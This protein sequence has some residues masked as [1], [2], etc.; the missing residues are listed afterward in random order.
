MSWSYLLV[1]NEALDAEKVRELIDKQPEITYWYRCLPNSMFLT[2]S[3]SASQISNLIK[4]EFS[5]RGGQRFFI[6]E[7]HADRQGWLPR[8]VWHMLKN[9]DNPGLPNE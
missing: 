4:D 7:V 6:T 3:L 8:A 5:T 2:S 9:P 1:F